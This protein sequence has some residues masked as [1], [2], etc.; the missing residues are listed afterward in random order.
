MDG[1]LR[2]NPIKMDDLGVPPFT[3]T[4]ISQMDEQKTYLTSHNRPKIWGQWLGF[5]GF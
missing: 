4:P 5:L 2:E 3:E 1:L